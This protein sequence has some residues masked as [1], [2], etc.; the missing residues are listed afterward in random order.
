MTHRSLLAEC[1]QNT[2]RATTY[3]RGLP[4]EQSG[5]LGE[6]TT[7]IARFVVG[8]EG[9]HRKLETIFDKARNQRDRR[10]DVAVLDFRDELGADPGAFRDDLLR[11]VGRFAKAAKSPR[12]VAWAPRC[13]CLPLLHCAASIHSAAARPPSPIREVAW[14]LHHGWVST[15]A[16][17]PGPAL[18]YLPAARRSSTQ[19]RAGWGPGDHA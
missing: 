3:Q 1:L 12:D 4:T 5:K 19:R 10:V 18:A 2:K 17:D 16:V 14:D 11:D 8:E 9:G 15:G 7:H 13:R 6:I